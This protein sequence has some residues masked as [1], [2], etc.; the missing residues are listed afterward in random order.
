MKTKLAIIFVSFLFLVSCK[1]GG[2]KG[3]GEEIVETRELNSFNK[4]DVSGNFDVEVVSGKTQN[5]EIFSETN[6]IGYIKTKVK[7]NTLYIYSK[8]NLRP[9]IDSHIDISVPELVAIEC[10]GANSIYATGIAADDFNIDLS[11]AGSINIEG[12]TK[13]L[14]IDVSGAADLSANNFISENLIIDVSGAANAEI[15]ASNSAVADVSGAGNI[16]L[17]GDAKNVKTDVSGAGS[18]VRK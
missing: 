12:K 17:Y 10:S 4:I 1:I 13:N 16:E 2:I 8:E 14:N 6:L 11:G 15:Y 7:G 9:T 3:N 5:I 18:L